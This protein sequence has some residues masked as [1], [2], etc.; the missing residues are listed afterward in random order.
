[1]DFWLKFRFF[2]Q[3]WIFYWNFDFFTKIGFFTEI[4]ICSLKF[5]L[6]SKI[7][8]FVRKF[9][10]NIFRR[11]DT[12]EN[13]IESYLEDPCSS[14]VRPPD[15]PFSDILIQS[16]AKEKLIHCTTDTTRS[17]R[18]HVD[19]VKV[20]LTKKKIFDEKMFLWQQFLLTKKIVFDN[21]FFDE[22][23]DFL[24]IK[25]WFLS[26]YLFL[27]K[28]LIFD[29]NSFSTKNCTILFL[30]TLFWTLWFL[31]KTVFR[32]KITILYVQFYM[33][34][35]FYFWQ[36]F[37]EQFDFWQ[38]ICFFLTNKNWWPEN[39]WVYDLLILTINF[40][41]K[42]IIE[43]LHVGTIIFHSNIFGIFFPK[44]FP[45][46]VIFHEISCGFFLNSVRV[47]CFFFNFMRWKI[48]FWQKK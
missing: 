21:N 33:Y 2:H 15:Q 34:I 16:P 39:S 5:P 37:F 41:N 4:S 30:T 46:L 6:L 45:E 38:N 36:H 17:F 25:K 19:N 9:F 27:T 11:F 8:I 1:M 10:K 31:T 24:L 20:F 28:D 43:M 47:C 35:Q 14:P 22:K 23:F 7:S 42:K 13:A 40:P 12:F 44:T 29:E 3:N 48:D 26:K 18:D 32:Q